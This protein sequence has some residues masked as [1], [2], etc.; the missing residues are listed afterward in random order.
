MASMSSRGQTPIDWGRVERW[1]ASILAN[2]PSFIL[3]E[4]PAQAQP[5]FAWR[6]D[7]K[8]LI[9]DRLRFLCRHW[10]S[11]KRGTALPH[12]RAIDPLNMG[13]ILGYVQLLEPVDGDRDFRY[14]LFGTAIASVSELDLTGR[15]ASELTASPHVV[16]FGLASYRAAARRMDGLYTVRTPVGAYRTA[17]WHRLT[18]PLVDDAGRLARL[19]AVSIPVAVDGRVL[20]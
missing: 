6:P 4:F 11:L 3:A 9:S 19:I 7:P 20:R 5:S 15:F 10:E 14:R 1:T 12:Y 16:E 8:S 13:P 18:L 2:D 17:Q